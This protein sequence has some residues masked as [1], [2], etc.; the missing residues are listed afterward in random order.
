MDTHDHVSLVGKECPYVP[1]GAALRLLDLLVPLNHPTSVDKHN[2]RQL[3][4]PR[5]LNPRREID[6]IRMPLE[7][8]IPVFRW[9][10]ERP[11]G[12]LGC[13]EGKVEPECRS[14]VVLDRWPKGRKFVHC[15]GGDGT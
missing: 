9:L 1:V 8:P 11:L 12:Y 2:R 5:R 13:E 4:L 3:V 14:C 10:E 6:V 15:H 7:R